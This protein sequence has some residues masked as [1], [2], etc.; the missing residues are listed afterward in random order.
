M[1]TGLSGGE[2]HDTESACRS[3]RVRQELIRNEPR[4]EEETDGGE[5]DDSKQMWAREDTRAS[6]DEVG[7]ENE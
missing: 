6:D 3:A 4:S 2:E 5:D 7:M 1:R